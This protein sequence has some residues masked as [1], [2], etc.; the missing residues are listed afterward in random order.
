M[1]IDLVEMGRA[2]RQA[3]RELV[4][5]TTAQKNG[6]LLAVA[7]EL[8]RNAASILAE[9][10]G[11]VAAGRDKGLSAALLDRLLLT[12][13]RIASLAA[14]VRRVADLPDPVGMEIMGRV[15]PNG[16]RLS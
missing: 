5:L 4:K 9:N 6:A 10:E 15:L 3:S 8:E 11:D 7:A 1:T 2:A 14:D 13:R 16:L 12:E